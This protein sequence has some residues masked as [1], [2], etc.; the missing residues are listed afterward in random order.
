MV[1]FDLDFTLWHPELYQLS[2]GPPFTTAADGCVLTARGERLDLFPAARSAL[3]ELADTGVPVAIASRASDREVLRALPQLSRPPR[4]TLT[5]V[6]ASQTQWALEIM[7]L[8]RVDDA[9]TV[10][11]V[12][13]DAP[14]VIRS[15]SKVGHFKTIAHESGVPLREMLF[16]DNERGNIQE[17]SKLG[18]TCVYCPRGLKDGV[19]RDGLAEHRRGREVEQ[20]DKEAS[21]MSGREA[22]HAA[23]RSKGNGR[24]GGRRGRR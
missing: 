22:R 8:L 6:T 24:K 9:R 20:A 12:V 13:G 21:K 19:F 7:R 14:V 4:R 17:V 11:D 10:A 3:V 1:V 18:V 16:F 15:G 2:S 23:A 5:R